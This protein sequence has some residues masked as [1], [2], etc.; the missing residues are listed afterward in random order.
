MGPHLPVR[1]AGVAEA[2]KSLSSLR[3]ARRSSDPA[4]LLLCDRLLEKVSAWA[5]VGD[6]A[7]FLKE[8]LCPSWSYRRLRDEIV[9]VG[10]AAQHVRHERGDQ[11]DERWSE[12]LP[13]ANAM[14]WTINR[15]ALLRNLPWLIEQ[16]PEG[17]KQRQQAQRLQGRTITGRAALAWL[18]EFDR[19]FEVVETRA[20]RIRNAV[21]HGGPIV[22]GT[23]AAVVAFMDELTANALARSVEG[24]LGGHDLIDHFLALRA[25]LL[26][27]RYRLSENHLPSDA[28]FWGEGRD[29]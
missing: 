25:D 2:C 27:L 28:L 26:Q 13:N 23:M 16:L 1:D 3:L 12:I 9:D 5:G 8:Y 22:E 7:Y 24:R 21:A 18:R 19:R 29:L 4:R 11:S 14:K 17:S 10:W 20:R 15:Q 6:R